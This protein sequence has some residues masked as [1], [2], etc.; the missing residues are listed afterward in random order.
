MTEFTPNI[1][2]AAAVLRGGP[3][4]AKGLDDPWHRAYKGLKMFGFI[5]TIAGTHREGVSLESV[6]ANLRAL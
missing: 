5:Q 2:S 1:L 3:C 6:R 4:P